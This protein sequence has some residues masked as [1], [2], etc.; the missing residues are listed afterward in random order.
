MKSTFVTLAAI[1]TVGVVTSLQTALAAPSDLDLDYTYSGDTGR[2]D[3]TLTLDEKPSAR[4]TY[5]LR[6]LISYENGVEVEAVRT[7]GTFDPRRRT[8]TVTLRR[9][10]AVELDGDG[11]RPI[12][13]LQA[14][15]TCR[16]PKVAI[17]SNAAA[18]YVVC[19]RGTEEVTPKIFLRTLISRLESAVD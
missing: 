17:T 2:I 4:C 8:R 13:T 7:L 5:R 6:G 10:P 3:V 11:N 12:L 1:L 15:L 9:L 16:R 18:Q 14:N 19:G